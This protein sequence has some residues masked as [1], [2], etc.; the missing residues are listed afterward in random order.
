MSQD[1]DCYCFGLDPALIG[2]N[3]F[4][5]EEQTTGARS[6]RNKRDAGP[7]DAPVSS[8]P[9]DLFPVRES[10]VQPVPQRRETNSTRRR[11]TKNLSRSKRR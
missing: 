7:D 4:E 9:G 5:D 3:W 2:V 1:G 6:K 8:A 10:T 11:A